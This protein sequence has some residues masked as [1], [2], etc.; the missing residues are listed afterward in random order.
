MS[1]QAPAALTGRVATGALLL[2]GA[3][4]AGVTTLVPSSNTGLSFALA[5]VAASVV[6]TILGGDRIRHRRLLRALVAFGGLALT[7]AT[8]HSIGDTAAQATLV[9]GA[10]VL[11]WAALAWGQGAALQLAIP[12]AAAAGTT[13][14][15]GAPAVPAAALVVLP[16]ALVVAEAVAWPLARLRRSAGV[17]RRALADV[18]RLLLSALDLR[19]VDDVAAAGDRVCRL[20]TDLLDGAGALLYV[21]GPGRLLLAGRHGQHPAPLDPELGS[22]AEMEEVLRLGAV[23]GGDRVLVPVTGDAGVIGVLEVTGAR[24]AV[25]QLTAG[26]AQL[27]GAQVGFV[28][29]RLNAVESLFDDATRDAVTGVG[30]RHQATAV[31]A[32][33]R[34]G[35][36]MLILDVDDFESLRRGQGEAAAN[37]LLGQVG[38]HLRNG[39][40]TGDAAARLGDHRFVVALREL[41]APIEMVVARLVE[42]WLA[43]SASRTI[44]VGGALHLEGHAPIDTVERAEMALASAQR[45]GGGRGHVAPDL[46]SLTA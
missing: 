8:L 32:S 28:L 10:A 46:S 1:D 37:L 12:A 23:K 31:I 41:K 42:T 38:L 5:I 2:S 35:D 4:A 25:D 27:F 44:S 30:N 36:G 21:Q 15:N 39:T 20:G 14:V 18:D 11:L 22:D 19:G 16:L 29:D 6:T 24:R 40:R 13:W 34:P 43:S 7:G 45:R 33:L 9:S 26:T 17:A 3:V